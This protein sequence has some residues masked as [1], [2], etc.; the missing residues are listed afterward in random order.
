[1]GPVADSITE[2]EVELQISWTAD[3]R[4]TQAILRQADLMGF[5]SGTAYLLQALSATIASNETD[6]IVS[7]D[8]RI[9]NGRDWV[10]P[11]RVTKERVTSGILS[12][13]L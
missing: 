9:L 11:R 12:S 2:D 4:T 3:E 10:R 6:T 13:S 8:G 7:N 1:L 5:E